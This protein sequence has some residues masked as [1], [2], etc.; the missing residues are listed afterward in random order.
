MT[1][2]A[3]SNREIS[4]SVQVFFLESSGFVIKIVF[5]PAELAFF[6]RK[7]LE[8]FLGLWQKGGFLIKPKGRVDF[9]ISFEERLEIDVIKKKKEKEEYY[10]SFYKDFVHRR[11]TTFYYQGLL[12]FQLA[13]KE[14]LA[15]LLER[16]NGFLL[17]A[18]SCLD[19]RGNLKVFLAPSGGGKTTTVFML[20]EGGYKAFG[21]DLLVVRKIDG[22]WKYFSPPF[23]EKNL[24]PQKKQKF[25]A[26]LF[27]IK[28]SKFFSKKEIVDE[29]TAL[30]LILRQV[31]LRENE[32]GDKT[33]KN[34][35]DFVKNNKFYWLETKLDPEGLRKI[36][37]ED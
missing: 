8:E 21:D 5:G 26:K 34:V 30:K 3:Y 13:L 12:S 2:L 29:G 19:K 4:E 25:S 24:T 32:V 16:N 33:F 36:I 37:D 31:W 1:R 11:A 20:S 22:K 7:L 6:K 23:V 27:F 28:K 15:Y 17:H 14:V 10:L 35:V 9:T 18:S